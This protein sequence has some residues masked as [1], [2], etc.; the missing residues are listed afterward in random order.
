M[1]MTHRNQQNTIVHLLIFM[2]QSILFYK[3]QWIYRLIKSNQPVYRKECAARVY[4]RLIPS[5]ALTGGNGRGFGTTVRALR[6]SLRTQACHY[7][8]Q[9]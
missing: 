9:Q 8:T 4:G 1:T 2:Q 3:K 6:L 7:Y 5:N